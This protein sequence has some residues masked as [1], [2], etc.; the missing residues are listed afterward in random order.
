VRLDALEAAERA[1][2]IE[3][4]ELAVL[5]AVGLERRFDRPQRVGAQRTA[6]GKFVDVPEIR[7]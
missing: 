2:E 4:I 6:T 7:P 1:L 3:R 5:D